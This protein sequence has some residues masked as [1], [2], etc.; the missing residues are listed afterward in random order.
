MSRYLDLDAFLADEERVPCEFLMPAAELSR[1]LD[2]SSTSPNIPAGHTVELPLWLAEALLPRQYVLLKLPRVFGP[3]VLDRLAADAPSVRLRDRC[4]AFYEVGARL[5]SVPSLQ[6]EE[7]EGLPAALKTALARR[8]VRIVAMALASTNA[9]VSVFKGTLTDLEQAAF[10]RVLAFAKD[11]AAWRKGLVRG[12]E[13]GGGGGSSCA[14]HARI[15]TSPTHP[16]RS[17]RSCPG[18]V[19]WCRGRS[20]GQRWR[21]VQMRETRTFGEVG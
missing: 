3:E 8:A 7:A 9:D 18:R 13:D 15:L 1:A 5:S 19:G 20:G 14:T 4:A 10:D 21:A 16:P 11:K 6:S 17:T 12:W 2:P